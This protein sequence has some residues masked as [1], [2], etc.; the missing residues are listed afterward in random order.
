VARK[1]LVQTVA[2]FSGGDAGFS[3]RRKSE[4]R[5]KQE[6]PRVNLRGKLVEKLNGHKATISMRIGW[7]EKELKRL[8]YFP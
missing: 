7:I 8:G 1:V 5:R 4:Q 2:G 6:A 3:E